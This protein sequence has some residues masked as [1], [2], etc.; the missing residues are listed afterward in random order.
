MEARKA[1][2]KS[3]QARR[4]RQSGRAHAHVSFRELDYP[5][6]QDLCLANRETQLAVTHLHV[7][8]TC[9]KRY[10]MHTILMRGHDRL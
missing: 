10:N 6:Q 2:L 3:Q 7:L 8:R 1:R 9:H 4:R 5:A